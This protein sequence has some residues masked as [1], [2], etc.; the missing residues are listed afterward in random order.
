MGRLAR[1]VLT[2]TKIFSVLV[3]NP[4]DSLPDP[5]TLPCLLDHIHIKEKM[6]ICFRNTFSS[7]SFTLTSHTNLLNPSIHTLI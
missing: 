5:S 7:S 1:P 6:H 3:F 4:F 2:R